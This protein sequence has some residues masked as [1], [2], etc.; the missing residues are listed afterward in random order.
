LGAD[1]GSIGRQKAPFCHNSRKQTFSVIA[2][3][4]CDEAIQGL[5]DAAP[6]TRWGSTAAPRLHRFA[7]NDWIGPDDAETARAGFV[8]GDRPKAG[9]EPAIVKRLASW[10]RQSN[11][12]SAPLLAS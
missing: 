5:R 6:E 11:T 12:V 7:R 2:R 8:Q 1:C 4:P 9:A 3:S 10:R